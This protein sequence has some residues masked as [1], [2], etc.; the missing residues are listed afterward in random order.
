MK[1]WLL[2]LIV[3]CLVLLRPL[4]LSV[5]YATIACSVLLGRGAAFCVHVFGVTY[6]LL[7][8]LH[9]VNMCYESAQ[10]TENRFRHFEYAVLGGGCV[11]AFVPV[12]ALLLPGAAAGA[13]AALA[14]AALG[15]CLHAALLTQCHRVFSDLVMRDKQYIFL[16]WFVNIAEFTASLAFALPS[17]ISDDIFVVFLVVV[18][19][20]AMLISSVSLADSDCRTSSSSA[21]A[22][23]HSP[24]MMERGVDFV[25]SRVFLLLWS[26]VTVAFVTAYDEHAYIFFVVGSLGLAVIAFTKF[27]ERARTLPS[28][29]FALIAGCTVLPVSV[30]AAL[31]STGVLNRSVGVMLVYLCSAPLLAAMLYTG[32]VV[33]G[34]HFAWHMGIVFLLQLTASHILYAILSNGI[35]ILMEC[36]TI[37]TGMIFCLLEN[38]HRTVVKKYFTGTVYPAAAA[39]PAAPSAAVAVQ[40]EFI[41]RHPPSM[42]RIAEGSFNSELESGKYKELLESQKRT[43][44]IK[45]VADAVKANQIPNALGDEN[46]LSCVSMSSAVVSPRVS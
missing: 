37:A 35:P 8:V 40:K 23:T 13:G 17:V 27:Q 42:F 5:G 30:L 39:A 44:S 41:Q 3:D 28:A 1:H 7:V 12:A 21:H 11:H 25:T 18:E 24:G 6:F 46:S 34:C 9:K 16:L 26:C 15:L 36:C 32:R 4:H 14:H 43:E 19:T 38:K 29:T 22:P 20:S 31:T 33:L 10:S 45:S 2:D